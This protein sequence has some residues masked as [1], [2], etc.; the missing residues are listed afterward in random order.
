MKK[1]ME[2]LASPRQVLLLLGDSGGGKSTFID[3]LEHTL[4]Q[5][6]KQ[7]DLIPLHINLST[8]ADPFNNMV[9]KRLEQLNF[10]P[11]QIAELKKSRQFVVI[12][13]G[14]DECQLKNNLY[15]PNLFNQKGQWQVKLVITCRTQYL[16]KDY[17]P[18]FLP[19]DEGQQ[20]GRQQEDDHFQEAFIAPFSRDQV[21][22]YVELYV[23]Q[24]STSTVVDQPKRSTNEVR[25]NA[26]VVVRSDSTSTVTG[27]PKWTADDYIEKL[28]TIHGLMELVSNP[29]LLSLALG[30]LPKTIQSENDM[31]N[32]QLTSVRLYDTFTEQWLKKGKRQLLSRKKTSEEQRAFEDL[33]EAD[34]VEQGIIFQKSLAAAIFEHQEGKPVVEYVQIT[35]K[36]SWK[37]EFFGPEHVAALLRE[38]SPLLKYDKQH[39]FIHR[40]IMEY[41][42]ARSISDPI[43]QDDNQSSNRSESDEFRSS[44][45]KH[46][47]NQR[48]VVEEP[49]I[50]QFL[51]E[52]VDSDPSFKTLLRDAVESS[53]K[54]KRVIKAATNAMSIMVKAGVSFH[55]AD[56]S[57]IKVPGAL[58][59][60]GLFD[61]TD[62]RGADLTGA[63]LSKAWLRKANLSGA[64][65]KGVEFEELPHLQMDS[66]IKNCVFSSN[67]KLLFVCSHIC[68]ID[69]YDTT[70]WEKKYDLLG[71]SALAISPCG[72][73]FANATLFNK[74]EVV[75]VEAGEVEFVLSGHQDSIESICYSPNGDLIATGS[76]DK[77]VRIWRPADFDTDDTVDTI[78]AL[79]VL[80]GHDHTVTG[81]AFSPLG[82]FFASCSMDMTI[83]ITNTKTWSLA[84]N[85]D[86]AAPVLALAY[87]PD[88]HQLASCGQNADLRLWNT[89]SSNTKPILLKGHEG[90][91]FD[92]AYSPDGRR[93]A[94]CGSDGTARLWNSD[95]GGLFDSLPGDRYEANCIAFSPSTTDNLLP[96][97]YLLVSGGRDTRLRMWKTGNAPSANTLN[98]GLVSRVNCV[99]ISMDGERIVAGC[100]GGAVQ[101]WDTLTGKPGVMLKGHESD[102]IGVAFS[103]DGEQVVSSSTDMKARLWS[104]ST[105][106]LLREFK[107]QAKFGKGLAFALDGTRFVTSYENNPAI[108]LWDTQSDE[109]L[110]TLQEHPV[111][112]LATLQEHADEVLDTPQATPQEIEINGIIYSPLGDQ[113]ASWS[114]DKTVRLWSTETNRRLYVLEHSE[115]VLNVAYSHDGQHLISSTA[116]GSSW[117]NT[118]TGEPIDRFWRAIDPV[119]FWCSY[120]SDGKYLATVEVEKNRFHLWDIP[121][122][123]A[124][125]DQGGKAIFNTGIGGALRHVWRRCSSN[126]KMI[127][128][129]IDTN[130]SLRVRELTDDVSSNGDQGSLQLM[131]S[132]GEDELSM[133]DAILEEVVGLS[134]ANL[135]LMKQRAEGVEKVEWSDGSTEKYF[136]KWGYFADSDAEEEREKVPGKRKDENEK[137]KEDE[138][139]VKKDEKKLKKDEKKVKKDEKRARVTIKE[140]D[141]NTSDSGMTRELK[142][143]A[144]TIKRAGTIKQGGTDIQPETPPRMPPMRRASTMPREAMG[145][146]LAT[147]VNEEYQ[148]TSST[149]PATDTMNTSKQEKPSRSSSPTTTQSTTQL[150]SASAKS[151]LANSVNT[152]KSLLQQGQTTFFT[153]NVTAPTLSLALPP[154]GIRFESTS[155]LVHCNNL[156]R[157]YLATTT[158]TAT[159]ATPLDPGQQVLVQ[160]FIQNQE[161]SRVFGLTYRKLLSCLIAEFECAGLLDIALLQGLV[162]L[163]ECAGP[164]YLIAN[165]LVKILAVIRNRLQDTQQQLTKHHYYL[166]LALSHHLDVM[167]EGKVKDLSRIT[168]HEPLSVLL[169]Q[170]LDNPDFHLTHQVTYALQGLLHIPNDETHRDYILRHTGNITMGLLGVASICK[171]NINEFKEGCT[172][173]YW[174]FMTLSPGPLRE[175]ARLR[176]KYGTACS[177]TLIDSSLRLLVVEMS[178]FNGG[179]A[180]FLA[181]SRSIHS[182]MKLFVNTLSTFSLISTGTALSATSTKTSAPISWIFSSRLTTC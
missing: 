47:L 16:G 103:P 125:R 35:D 181:T 118:Q 147:L 6:Y 67:G 91:V 49:S 2:F 4:W 131:W 36:N 138:K 155:Q 12:C 86:C 151:S 52:C 11:E 21:K 144:G 106:Q 70:T 113:I 65:M 44:L 152:Q 150:N 97:D 37:A 73:E 7:N 115:A 76:K 122:A 182:G 69:V 27:L 141:E 59:Q 166:T 23:Q 127:L 171:L 1:T 123:T 55:G 116:G 173:L 43:K 126:G 38:S 96:T 42:Y 100:F 81:V 176:K 29:F 89:N 19:I 130:F 170:L 13:D 128:A 22:E 33:C 104:T 75:N 114:D 83:R 105:G 58:L 178:S 28:S 145:E 98:N 80:P 39:R 133:E 136:T 143:L 102:V 121:T 95:G 26:E 5:S 15:T 108:Q 158:S 54:D 72:E 9:G 60:G 88:G 168:D 34:F 51:V 180:S 109:M 163:I 18:L 148:P 161:Q 153:Q 32:I 31:S 85:L 62:L 46:P 74:A 14:Y 87:S 71:K 107:G 135:L 41:L 94:S 157:R 77:T 25:D 17:R 112:V 93:V 50:L 57:G 24:E 30:A 79:R 99:D 101:L 137:G 160:P 139:K 162:H 165:D 129:S 84:Y 66:G 3:Q 68:S 92:V 111:E 119:I 140:P 117:W 82:D 132:V 48:S 149:P 146:L 124:D 134:A 78:D 179:S 177:Q 175:H 40:S 63:N 154:P 156:L 164:S 64:I 110:A 142:K 53:K 120:S 61:S 10:K 8:I 172:S 169:T 20:Q 159:T 56:L 90:T 174:M 45:A 167:V